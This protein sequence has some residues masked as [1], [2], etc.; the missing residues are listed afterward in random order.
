MLYNN[1][2]DLINIGNWTLR[3]AIQFTFPPGFNIPPFSYVAIV[4]SSTSI[5]AKYPNISPSSVVGNFEGEL[6]NNIGIIELWNELDALVAAIEYEDNWQRSTDGSVPLSSS[7]VSMPEPTNKRNW[8]ASP[9]PVKTP[10]LEYSGTPGSHNSVTQCI[11]SQVFYSESLLDANKFNVLLSEIMYHP[12][13][14]VTRFEIHEFIEIYNYGDEAVDL[15]G[16]MLLTDDK[17]RPVRYLPI[18]HNHQLQA[19]HGDS[20]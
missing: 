20:S 12:V 17:L 6:S 4:K 8:R 10:N 14:E 3:N 18:T 15:S 19:A 13:E 9:I 1:A 2:E 16:W 5:L 11:P 7:R